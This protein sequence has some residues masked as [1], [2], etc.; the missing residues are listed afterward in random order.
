MKSD[1]SEKE[2]AMIEAI[3][4]HWA[5]VIENDV[6]STLNPP[7]VLEILAVGCFINNEQGPAVDS[8]RRCIAAM[9]SCQTYRKTK[10]FDDLIQ[11]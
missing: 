10:A 11:L 8:L 9:Q 5:K 1:Y 4:P 7:R 6:D 3:S 2:M